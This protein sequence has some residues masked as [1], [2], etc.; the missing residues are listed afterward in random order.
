VNRLLGVLV[1]VALI[2]VGAS[3]QVA[4]DVSATYAQPMGDFADAVKLGYGVQGDV[5]Y[6]PFSMPNL[7]IGGR[8]GWTRFSFDAKALDNE[9][10]STLEIVPSARYAFTPADS[11]FGIFGQGGVGLYRGSVSY[12]NADAQTDV[13]F[14]VGGGASGK[15]T[16]TASFVVMPL[17]HWVNTEG[18]A[19]TYLSFSFGVLF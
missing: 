3:G 5:F 9:S 12:G 14:C 4:L 19:T 18:N 1:L 10:Y 16:D 6:M 11:Q 2:A 15:F 13:G 8:L 17:Y 7:G